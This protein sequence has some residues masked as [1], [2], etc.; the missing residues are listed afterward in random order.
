MLLAS[1]PRAGLNGGMQI[2]A[3]LRPEIIVD[4]HHPDRLLHR[5]V[6]DG[7]RVELALDG[8]GQGCLRVRHDRSP[9]MRFVRRS[10][11]PH[12]ARR[13]G[14]GPF[15]AAIVVLG[16]DVE[17]LRIGE[18]ARDHLLRW[19]ARPG[20]W[21]TDAEVGCT[22]SSEAVDDA[23]DE[24]IDKTIDDAFAA[25]RA[26]LES[27]DASTVVELLR[28]RLHAPESLIPAIDQRIEAGIDTVADLDAIFAVLAQ[29]PVAE[30]A[31]W[32]SR[33]LPRLADHGAAVLALLPSP[34][35]AFDRL[36]LGWAPHLPAARRVLDERLTHADSATRLLQIVQHDADRLQM[37]C[38][39]LPRTPW[40]TEEIE[41]LAPDNSAARLARLAALRV[42]PP[43][44]PR[45][46]T[47]DLTWSRSTVRAAAE[48]LIGTHLA[49]WL[50]D[51][52][53]AVATMAV[54]QRYAS[55][56]IELAV[57]DEQPALITALAGQ[58]FSDLAHETQRLQA[59][60]RLPV[61]GPIAL[62]HAFGNPALVAPA[63]A[64]V[65]AHLAHWLDDRSA[66]S[67][68]LD[69]LP[70]M[71]D[72]SARIL[73]LCAERPR[74]GAA[75]VLRAIKPWNESSRLALIKAMGETGDATVEGTL[76]RWMER[77]YAVRLAC[78]EALAHV[79]QR[80]ALR[81]LQSIADGFLV[82][83]ALKTEALRAI[84]AIEARLGGGVGGLS[85]A[86]G[87]GRLSLDDG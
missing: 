29:H 47:S 63:Q 18:A 21:C 7:L 45:A 70:V 33:L 41:A 20:A 12:G 60:A 52:R 50:G 10:Q 57:R 32:L 24:A 46:L 23:I 28:T 54:A 73:S 39:A 62:R 67:T 44:D 30:R 75:R 74:P 34:P 11:H 4:P 56:F 49:H 1:A 61:S 37:L 8:M 87:D 66:D 31:H 26:L 48:A 42:R 9:R 59:L 86:G 17:L 82:E 27:L 6:V 68:L 84:S 65:H 71:P 72:L 43:G 77:G 79:G 16:A 25:A 13:T 64:V 80:A 78:I 38:D 83:R 5:G 22:L 14:H 40:S 35:P 81:A 55:T 85:L 53:T 3:R 36:V 51:P 19:L 15:D 69:A 58:V 76:L 2:L